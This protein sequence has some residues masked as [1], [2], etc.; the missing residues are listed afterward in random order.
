M[1]IAKETVEC[2]RKSTRLVDMSLPRGPTGQRGR[3]LPL[4]LH[5]SCGIQICRLLRPEAGQFPNIV[6]R[7][8]VCMI[9]LACH[10][11]WITRLTGRLATMRELI[12]TLGIASVNVQDPVIAEVILTDLP[13]EPRPELNSGF[14]MPLFACTQKCIEFHAQLESKYFNQKVVEWTADCFYLFLS[15]S[16][17]F[18]YL[19]SFRPR[20]YLGISISRVV[21]FCR[22]WQLLFKTSRSRALLMPWSSCPGAHF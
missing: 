17:I 4:V 5:D 8:E 9:I 19:T 1:T 10:L 7:E 14:K 13:V 3:I 18:Q 11:G 6:V 12:V 21:L 20:W 22:S 15:I 16:N 2:E